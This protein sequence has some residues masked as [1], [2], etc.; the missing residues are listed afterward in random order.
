MHA[1]LYC[2]P[3]AAEEPTPKVPLSMFSSKD[4]KVQQ[5]SRHVCLEPNSYADDDDASRSN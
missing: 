3:A 2:A 4:A 1:M 5:A